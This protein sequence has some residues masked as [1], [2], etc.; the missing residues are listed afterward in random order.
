MARYKKRERQELLLE[1]VST[2]PFL[3]DEKLSEVFEVSIQTIRLDRLELNIPELRERI[4]HVAREETEKIRS[5][6]LQE[7]IGEIIDIELNDHAL[8]LF[9][10]EDGHVF[11]KN[12]ITRG[13]YLFA[14]ANSLC[15]AVIDEPLALTKSADIEFTRASKLGDKVISKAVVE[16]MDGHRAIITVTS[17]VEQRLVFKGRFEMYYTDETD[18]GE[19]YG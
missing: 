10:V 11:Q 9:I 19:K 14:Q 4:K 12:K 16:K 18:E 7:V 6:S 17:R 5:L 1:K 8:S 2:D 15:V 13:H 3:T